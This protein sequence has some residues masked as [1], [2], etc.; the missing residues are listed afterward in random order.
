MNFHQVFLIWSNILEFSG[1]LLITRISG[2]ASEQW[3]FWPNNYYQIITKNAERNH[4]ENMQFL[5]WEAIL[6]LQLVLGRRWSP[7]ENS[8]PIKDEEPDDLFDFFSHEFSSLFVRFLRVLS[9]T[10]LLCSLPNYSIAT[11]LSEPNSRVL[12]PN[13]WARFL[14]TQWLRK[15]IYRNVVQEHDPFKNHLGSQ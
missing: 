12:Q 13:L 9:H 3:V 2:K 11:T 15:P 7:G 14:H 4:R 6:D 1:W 10:A 5:G 8:K